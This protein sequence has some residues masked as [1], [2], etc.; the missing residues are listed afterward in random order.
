MSLNL[1]YKLKVIVPG[2]KLSSRHCI[3]TVQIYLKDALI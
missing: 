1:Y 2:S 3:L